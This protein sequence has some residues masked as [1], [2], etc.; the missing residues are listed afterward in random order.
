[1]NTDHIHRHLDGCR[2]LLAAFD[3]FVADGD[4]DNAGSTFFQL[5][6][7]AD[8]LAKVVHQTQLQQLRERHC[9]A[10]NDLLVDFRALDKSGSFS[11]SLKSVGRAESLIEISKDHE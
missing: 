4:L 3:A 5:A 11:R 1:M 10:L 6:I 7:D 9:L 8:L 2:N